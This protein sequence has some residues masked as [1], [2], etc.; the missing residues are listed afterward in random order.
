MVPGSSG[1]VFVAASRSSA[2]VN[3]RGPQNSSRSLPGLDTE[4]D[5]SM[6]S[7]ADQG[8][9]IHAPENV[10]REFPQFKPVNTHAE[11]LAK[12]KQALAF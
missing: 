5:T 2:R 9:L 4:N 8:F 6:L 3:A 11:L 12:I 1:V 7:E 10:I